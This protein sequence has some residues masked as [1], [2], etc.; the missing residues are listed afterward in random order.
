M[1]KNLFKKDINRNIEGVIKADNLSEDAVFQEVDEYVITKEIHKRLDEFFS[2]YSFALGQPT[3]NIGCWISGHFGSGKSHLLKILSYILSSDEKYDKLIKELFLTKID[4][5]DFELKSNIEKALNSP[6]ETILFNIE[7]K[8]EVTNTESDTILEV[9]VKVFNE[10]RGYYPKIGYIAKFERD[11]DKRGKFEEFKE[12]F[13]KISGESWENGRE[14]L[15]LEIDNVAKALSEVDNISFE[16]AKEVI[17]KYEKTYSISV[18]EF[19]EEVKEYIQN[20]PKDFRLIFCVDEIGQFIGDNTRLML[21][22]QT[23]VESLA[24]ECKGQAWVIVT[25]Q[26]A[27]KE[28]VD[29][30]IK[31]E[32]DFSKILGR[33]KI[34]LN[35]TSQNANE[36]IQKRLLEK[37]D[38]VKDDLVNIYKKVENSLKSI[39]KFEGKTRDYKSYK[40][41]EDFIKWYP[42][43]PY[44]LDLFQSVIRSL[45]EHNFFQ[46]RH[47]STGER[48]MLGV[49]QYIAK[50]I[51]NREI[52]KIVTFD[53]FFD[54]ISSIIRAD[55]QTEINKAEDLLDE[56]ELRVLKVLFLIKYVK[57][58]EANLNNIAVL[59]V[60]DAHVDFYELKEKIKKALDV[61]IKDTYIQRVGD[62]YEYLTNLEKDIQTEINS[63]EID[64]SDITSKLSSWIYDNIIKVKKVRFRSVDYDFGKKLNSQI[65][66]GKEGE[67]NLNIITKE[68]SNISHLSLS[69]D[70][71][72][73]YMPLS[74]SIEKEIEQFIKTE[75]YIPQKNSSVLTSEE[76]AILATKEQENFKRRDNILNHLNDIV[77]DSKVYFNAEALQIETKDIKKKLEDGFAQVISKIYPYL[78]GLNKDYK[79]EDIKIILSNSSDLFKEEALSA[80][81]NEILNKIKRSKTITLKELIDTFSKRPY[82][83]YRNAILAIVASLKVK[84]LIDI[85]QNSTPLSNNELKSLLLNTRSYE[86]LIISVKKEIDNSKLKKVK[87]LLNE[88][89]NIESQNVS[90]IYKEFLNGIDSLII[91]LQRSNNYPFKE[92]AEEI[93]NF[94]KELKK[95][96]F[97][98]FIEVIESKEDDILDFAEEIGYILEFLN[99]EKSKIYEKIKDYIKTNQSNLKYAKEFDL[100]LLNDKN[101][102]RGNKIQKLNQIF[103]ELTAEIEEVINNEKEKA[104]LKID[105]LID[106]IQKLPEFEKVEVGKRNEIIGPIL[107]IKDRISASSNIDEIK[108]LSSKE[109][110]EKIWQFVYEKIA[111]LTKEEVKIENFENFLPKGKIIEKEEDVD[112]LINELRNKLL[113]KIHSNTKIII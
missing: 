25:S 50:Q 87:E 74:Y 71:L 108:Q 54:G 80:L 56:F 43:I 10:Y 4:D 65:V 111:E 32:N 106:K 95:T 88:F 75:K 93:I 112:E 23:I 44:Q 30:N 48:S 16:S 42:F 101:I 113:E 49:V 86:S 19:A 55:F 12:T 76:R 2:E 52:G 104:L 39:L 13:K 14:M 83:L 97:D 45:S 47:Q 107:R 68:D 15:F 59:L 7:Q 27:V 94:L 3:Q 70:D 102:H 99:G 22:L 96:D 33:F 36:V 5:S 82:G 53:M 8:A 46:G 35:L 26:S 91:T 63:F 98:D 51:A 69:S 21:N 9:F 66:K 28:L 1:I 24:I 73:F 31:M 38:E 40:N 60:D 109:E 103:K 77:A 18:E 100:S 58:F 57:E 41:E 34:K 90:D 67:L 78:S 92:K 79:E 37:K 72:I 20:K 62:V 84:N 17:D 29:S 64:K 61:L 110:E 6:S 105:E 11:L 85:K 81:E 89:L